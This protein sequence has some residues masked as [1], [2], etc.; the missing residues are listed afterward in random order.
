MSL[1]II[2]IVWITLCKFSPCLR[3][4]SSSSSIAMLLTILQQWIEMIFHSRFTAF[5]DAPWNFYAFSYFSFDLAWHESRTI[6]AWKIM[7]AT[8][9]SERSAGTSGTSGGQTYLSRNWILCPKLNKNISGFKPCNLFLQICTLF[10]FPNFLLFR[11][12][13]YL[14]QASDGFHLG[15]LAFCRMDH[16]TNIG[17]HGRNTVGMEATSMNF[18]KMCHKN[19]DA[20][21]SIDAIRHKMFT[22]IFCRISDSNVPGGSGGPGWEGGCLVWN[23]S[24]WKMPPLKKA[25][26]TTS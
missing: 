24:E 26:E 4:C 8:L 1:E 22:S 5:S 10:F 21:M 7:E 3:L 25:T 13:S 20:I 17:K 12:S 18:T 14:L 11:I 19:R 23:N 16:S 6:K 2:L 15:S 9:S